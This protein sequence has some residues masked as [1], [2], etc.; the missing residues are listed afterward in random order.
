VKLYNH[1]RY[2]VIDEIEYELDATK[3]T[4]SVNPCSPGTRLFV[5]GRSLTP[6]G[7]PNSLLRVER[8][9]PTRVGQGN[10]TKEVSDELLMALTDAYRESASGKINR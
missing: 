9:A 10:T 3:V 4:A 8:V 5:S 2:V 7:A 1:H 6:S